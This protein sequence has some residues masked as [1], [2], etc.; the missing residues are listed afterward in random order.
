[1][2]LKEI[3]YSR[4]AGL[5]DFGSVG[6]SLTAELETG[7]DVARSFQKLRHLVDGQVNTVL[8]VESTANGANHSVA[9]NTINAVGERRVQNPSAPPTDRQIALIEQ[10]VTRKGLKP[11][12]FDGLD[13]A[14]VSR[15]ID[16]LQ[17][18]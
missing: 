1:M 6:L 4:K 18:K 7:D 14:A 17:Q 5:P 13:R 16:E 12:S 11:V 2:F 9:A 3:T 8:K 10:L 15:L